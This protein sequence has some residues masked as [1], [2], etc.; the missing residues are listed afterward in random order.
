MKKSTLA[1]IVFNITLICQ[2]S[3]HANERCNT[4]IP[5]VIYLDDVGTHDQP[6]DG[7]SDRD[8]ANGVQD[9]GILMRWEDEMD[10]I[11][12]GSTSRFGNKDESKELIR[13]IVAANNKS[14]PVLS[15][16]ELIDFITVTAREIESCRNGKKLDVI[17]GGSWDEMMCALRSDPYV[18]DLINITGIGS[19]NIMDRDIPNPRDLAFCINPGE[20]LNSK[21]SFNEISQVMPAGSIFRI[22]D[23]TTVPATVPA[24]IRDFTCHNSKFTVDV[25]N[26]FYD[27]G[28]AP[29]LNKVRDPSDGIIISDDRS[30]YVKE[31]IELSKLQCNSNTVAYRD[32]IG[33][34]LRIAD[35][36]AVAHVLAKNYKT[37]NE[38]TGEPLNYLDR[39]EIYDYIAGEKK[40][41]QKKDISYL[42]PII[43]MLRED[44]DVTE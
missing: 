28:I 27:R 13:R 35:F 32:R 2:F 22:S 40:F 31:A 33:S 3:A 8:D 1:L 39:D 38:E 14:A 10:L 41:K 42:V 37:K 12:I 29:M 26:R 43:M 5:S 7:L 15:G 30:P 11:A 23:K 25:M 44:E 6:G 19:S 34:K 4:K 36:L 9:L 20:T 21:R 16:K 17:I 24:G 18:A